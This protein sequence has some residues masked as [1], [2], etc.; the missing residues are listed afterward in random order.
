MSGNLGL[1]STV[2]GRA[3]LAAILLGI[4]FAL[5]LGYSFLGDNDV[6]VRRSTVDMWM[7]LLLQMMSQKKKPSIF[8]FASIFE[9]LRQIQTDYQGFFVGDFSVNDAYASMNI[10]FFKNHMLLPFQ[11]S[12]YGYGYQRY[13]QQGY[14]NQNFYQR[15]DKNFYENGE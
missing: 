6:S 4:L 12:G 5:V 10:F 15:S 9:N 3:I 7:L 11:S 2:D 1:N 13:G 14:G 8:F